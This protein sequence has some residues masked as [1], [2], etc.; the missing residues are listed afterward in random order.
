MDVG[1]ANRLALQNLQIPELSTNRTLPK[2]I[3]PR[4]S[5]DK[6]RLTSSCP[7]AILVVPTKR[8]LRTNS[9]YP[10]RKEK[11]KKKKEKKLPGTQAV[12]TLPTSIKEKRI[13]RGYLDPLRSR[14]G[15]WG[16]REQSAPATATPPPSK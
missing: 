5:P 11:A 4:R 13:P 10:L 2:Y 7:D 9:W 6:Q 3:N 16:N 12:K 15:R 1:S 14:G 8:V